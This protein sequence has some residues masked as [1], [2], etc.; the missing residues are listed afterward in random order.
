MLLQ[1]GLVWQVQVRG[2]CVWCVCVRYVPS[3]FENA[4]CRFGRLWGQNTFL[5]ERR[6]SRH[7]TGP[8]N[9]MLPAGVKHVGVS[10]R[11]LLTMSAQRVKR[12]DVN[13]RVVRAR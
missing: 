7:S 5:E 3:V 9:K 1:G 6:Q 11:R 8:A 4:V 2:R 13:Q 12:G 10:C